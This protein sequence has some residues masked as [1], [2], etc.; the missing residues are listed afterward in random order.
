M[1]IDVYICDDDVYHDDDEDYNDDGDD[2]FSDVGVHDD[3]EMDYLHHHDDKIIPS[4]KNVTNH[5]Q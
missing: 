1:I 2:D 3:Y 4:L 5:K